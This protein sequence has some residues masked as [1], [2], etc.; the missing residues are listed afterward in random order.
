MKK[1]WSCSSVEL[2]HSILPTE[3]YDQ[4]LDEVA[5]IVYRRFCQ[6][7]EISLEAPELEP[8]LGAENRTGTNG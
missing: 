2:I 3:E 4:I 8:A 6:I 5:E 1:T 7:S